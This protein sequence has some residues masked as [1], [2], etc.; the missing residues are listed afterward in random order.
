MSE[1]WR[2]DWRVEIYPTRFKHIP[3]G[4]VMDY[5]YEDSVFGSTFLHGYKKP[6]CINFADALPI[7]WPEITE[8]MMKQCSQLYKEATGQ[9]GEKNETD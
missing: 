3:S 5:A 9:V 6:F 2:K 4:W 1:D 7:A 8:E